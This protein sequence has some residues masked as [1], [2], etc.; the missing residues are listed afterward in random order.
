VKKRVF[1]FSSLNLESVKKLVKCLGRK[2]T[3]FLKEAKK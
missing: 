2:R 1:R 3:S